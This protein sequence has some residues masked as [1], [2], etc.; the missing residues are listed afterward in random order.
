MR[1]EKPTL[2]REELNDRRKQRGDPTGELTAQVHETPTPI[3][4][5]DLPPY[6]LP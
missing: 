3:L 4:E 6:V 2:A 5:S 1:R